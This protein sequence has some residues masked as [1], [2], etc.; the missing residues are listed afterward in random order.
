MLEL[1]V[2][3]HLFNLCI[4][5]IRNVNDKVLLRSFRYYPILGTRFSL[6]QSSAFALTAYL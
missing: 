5:P 6:V 3:L 2:L 4:I 1:R